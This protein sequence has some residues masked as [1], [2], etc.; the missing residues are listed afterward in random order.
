MRVFIQYSFITITRCVD[1]V[2]KIRF[3]SDILIDEFLLIELLETVSITVQD[4]P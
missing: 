4:Y 1:F 2:L 3:G